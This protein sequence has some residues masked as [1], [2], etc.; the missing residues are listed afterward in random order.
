M[1]KNL[2]T[3]GAAALLALAMGFMSAFLLMGGIG[4]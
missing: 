2:S 4:L 1:K 3:R